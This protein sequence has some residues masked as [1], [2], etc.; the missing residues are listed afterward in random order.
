MAPLIAYFRL[1][2]RPGRDVLLFALRTVVAGLLCLYL[3]FVFDL[4]QPKWALMTVIIIS[5]PLAGMTLKRSLAQVLGTVVGAAVAVLLMALFAQMPYTLV[6]S[7]ALWLGLC[8]AGGTLLRYTDSHAFV[9]SGF[10]AVVVAMLAVPEPEGTFLLAVTRVTETLLAVACVAVVSL[11]T[12][13]PQPVANSYFAKVDSLLKLIAQHAAEVIR[14][15]ED[16]AAFGQRQA[17]LIAEVSALEGLRRHLYFDAPHLRSGDGLVQLFANQLVLLV[18]RLLV[19]RQQRELVK[20]HWQGP[21]PTDIQVLRDAELASLDALARDGMALSAVD[22]EAL[23]TLHKGFDDAAD[24]AEF[25]NEPLPPQL[26]A[27]A[28]ALRWEQARLLQ[29]L[30]ELI[31]LNEAIQQ[32]RLASCPRQQSRASTLHLDWPLAAMNAVRACL[33]LLLIGGLWIESAWDGAR[34][35][36]ILMGV[37][38]SLMATLPRPLL[39]SQ[40]YNRGLLVGM[41]LSALYQFAV[42][43]LFTDFEMLA[44]C[45]APLLYLAAVGLANP[46]TAGIGM[47][48]GLIS[49]LMIGPQN[50]GAYHNSDIQWFEFAGGYLAAG[51]LAM[52]VFALVFPFNAQKR[53]A[54]LFRQTREDVRRQVLESGSLAGQFAFESLLLDRL[55]ALIGLLPAAPDAASRERVECALVCPALAIALGQARTL[56]NSDLE[57]PSATRARLRESLQGVAD[58]IGG[59][60]AVALD[61]LLRE[62]SDQAQVLDAL[63]GAQGQMGRE[64]LRR[65]FILRV[66]LAVAGQLLTRYRRVLEP[67]GSRALPEVA[68]A[69]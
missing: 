14:T 32:G 56:C 68:D 31:E 47:G 55:S 60:G 8:T 5:L 7:L 42:L 40:N 64:A 63:H 34:S 67:E 22:R 39:A 23:R 19:L 35:A 57:L 51:V 54:R 4:E 38:C 13:R 28:W 49:L 53:I 58:F 11:L 61:P 16:E 10:T 59:Q 30:D 50:V 26:R 21:L 20:A 44:L 24:R 36:V 37:M 62:L 66:A 65:L 33:A 27:L 12:A 15:E 3:A 2:L 48:I 52:A 18:S 6:V 43:P 41:G 17:R 1:A 25:L 29:Q 69:H 9:L 45:L 46:M